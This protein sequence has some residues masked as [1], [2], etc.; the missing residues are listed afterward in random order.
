[1][2]R[3]FAAEKLALWPERGEASAERCARYYLAL[4]G[5]VERTPEQIRAVS[6]E[7][8]NVRQAW[9]WA[10]AK[11]DVAGLAGAS[12]GLWNFYLQKGLFQE[13]EEAFGRAI[14]AVL[15]TPSHIA[16]RRRALASLRVAQA[17][18]LNIRN[19]YTEAIA[20]AEEAIGY[21]LQEEDEAIIAQ[22][23]LQWGTA[24]YRQGHYSA[25]VQRFQMALVAA[26]DG[27]LAADQ[28]DILRLLGVAWL[29]Q[30]DF[31]QAQRCGEEALTLYRHTGNW[32]GEGNT[33]TDLGWMHQR[34]QNFEEAR[35]YLEEAERT[36]TAIDNRHGATIARLNLGIVQQMI[37]DFSTALDTYQQLFQELGD[38][39]DP[40]HHSLVNHSLGVLYT[41]MGDYPA[42]RR[43]LMTALEINRSSG[44]RGGLA[45]S[46]NGLGMIHNHLGNAK[47]GL[48]YH[49]Q[50]LEIG[51][52]QGAMTVEGIAWLGI[53]QDLQALGQWAQA[54]S[55]YETAI[56]IQSKLK[57]NVRVME[58][59][60][61]L[62][63]SLLA[64]E[65]PAAAL[66]QVEDLLDYLTTGPLQ[67]AAQPALLYWN[68]YAVLRGLGDD[69]APTLLAELFAFVQQKAAAIE[70][71][72]L[73]RSYLHALP[74]HPAILREVESLQMSPRFRGVAVQESNVRRGR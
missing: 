16:G 1:M 48:A 67:G 40:Y 63:R 12:S 34:Q 11:G 15:A 9:N 55:A 14:A 64:L 10:V 41:R 30:G 26:Q 72:R 45:W 3:Q 46:Y 44:D 22:G 19:H 5:G 38:Q 18:F 21:G 57:Q 28:A 36:H 58:S 39:P 23:Y 25:A 71:E 47:T 61:G 27:A 6:A 73:R 49:K 4:I 59:R 52:E 69:R 20:L 42:A 54:R 68:C 7:L 35:A 74:P 70:D 17:V 43:H 8:A 29:E 50:A 24:L 51:K 32:L 13:A 65:E 37:G 31:A 62:A 33:L 2:V 53:G 66:V 60:S 56:S